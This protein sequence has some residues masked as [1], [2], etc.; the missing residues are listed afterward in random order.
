[1]SPLTSWGLQTASLRDCDVRVTVKLTWRAVASIWHDAVNHQPIHGARGPRSGRLLLG[2]PRFSSEG[3]LLS[4]CPAH[5]KER[6]H[7]QPLGSQPEAGSVSHTLPQSRAGRKL[8][9][10]L[11]NVKSGRGDRSRRPTHPSPHKVLRVGRT[12][13]AQ[14][15]RGGQSPV[16]MELSVRQGRQTIDKP[17]EAR[18]VW[19]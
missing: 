15:S 8:A 19:L 7:G 1:M 3:C 14:Q 17:R 13:R 5:P 11:G 9:C 18:I 10:H 2:A 4:H 6:G 16:F 12:W